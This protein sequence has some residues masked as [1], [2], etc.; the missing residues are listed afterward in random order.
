MILHIL[1]FI[2]LDLPH[3][4]FQRILRF[5]GLANADMLAENHVCH[6]IFFRYST[7]WNFIFPIIQHNDSMIMLRQIDGKGI[8][9]RILDD[10]AVIRI[11]QIIIGKDEV[12]SSNLPS[13]STRKP[14]IYAGFRVFTFPDS[15]TRQCK[16]IEQRIELPKR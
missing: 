3:K 12:G 5:S 4:V 9:V 1:H 8:S 14:C 15:L 7:D 13:S 11:R 10:K 6:S 2:S 16:R